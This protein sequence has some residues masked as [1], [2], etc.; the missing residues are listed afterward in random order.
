MT[1]IAEFAIPDS[2]R[3][4]DIFSVANRSLQTKD[5]KSR[6]EAAG[7]TPTVNSLGRQAK[8]R[9]RLCHCARPAMGLITLWRLV[10]AP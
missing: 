8:L 2:V 7:V 9:L 6:T 10:E 3:I 4:L 5:V 1:A